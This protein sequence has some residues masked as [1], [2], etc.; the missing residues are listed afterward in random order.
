VRPFNPLLA[1]LPRLLRVRRTGAAAHDPLEK[2]IEFTIAES[3]ERRAGES[4]CAS[5]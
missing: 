1:T 2:L 5:G 3:R 4:A